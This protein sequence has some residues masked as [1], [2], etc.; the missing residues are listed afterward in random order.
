MSKKSLESIRPKE[1]EIELGD[2]KHILCYD[3]NS[4]GEMEDKYGSLEDAL[5]SL[6]S[7]KITSLRFILWAGLLSNWE[8]VTEREVGKLVGLSNLQYIVAKVNEALESSLPPVPE[9]ENSKNSE[10]N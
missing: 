4:F 5:Q 6:K 2:G 7:G 10:A 3:M 8:D 1:V 9:G